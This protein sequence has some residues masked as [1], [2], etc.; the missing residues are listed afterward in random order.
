MV[1]K[2]GI[3]WTNINDR[4]KIIAEI[5]GTENRERKEQS[6]R[7]VDVYRGQIRSYV[8]HDLICQHGPES[9]NEIPVIASVNVC[10]RIVDSD[11]RLYA[12]PVGREFIGVSEKQKETLKLIYEDMK[13]DANLMRSNRYFNLQQ[14][15]IFHTLPKS[16]KLEMRVYKMHQIDAVPMVLNPEKA[17]AY[18]V[19]NFDRSLFNQVVR[20]DKGDGINQNIA[21]YDDALLKAMVF[22]VW[23]LE[24][25]FLMNGKGEIL[26]TPDAHAD[27]V[28]AMKEVTSLTPGH[29]PFVDVFG[30]KDFTFFVEFGNELVDFTIQYNTALS[31]EAQIIKMQGFAQPFLK[32]PSSIFSKKISI[33]PDKLLRLPTDNL[34]GS[35]Q[36]EFGYANPNTD[37]AGVREHR[38]QLMQDFLSTKGISKPK[39]EGSANY[40]SGIERLLSMV[41]E[42]ERSRDAMSIYMNAED[43]LFDSVRNWHNAAIGTDLL[44]AKYLAGSRIPEGARVKVIYKK[45]EM[46]MTEEEKLRSQNL[47]VESGR[48]SNIMELMNDE[49]LTEKEAIA[50]F[51]K[52]QEHEGLEFGTITPEPIS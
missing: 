26:L 24:F 38:V 16:K 28:I 45:P 1:T 41:K 36:I 9:A 6:V 18:I 3:D 40:T 43:Q 11:S 10:K 17:Q 8:Q 19:S 22:A 15:N 34:Q 25:Q 20:S 37:L 33:G 2:T 44:D 5:M 39:F 12:E 51:K 47:K 50:K 42:F 23:D 27:K 30:E 29:L 13:A 49:G 32:G 7:E 48:S 46:V 31:N 14:Q 21:D 52:I 4:Q 35:E